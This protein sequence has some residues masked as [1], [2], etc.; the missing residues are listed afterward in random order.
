VATKQL[1]S[2]DDS[3]VVNREEVDPADVVRV[4]IVTGGSR[5]I[6]L[7]IVQAFLLGQTTTDKSSSNH[8]VVVNLDV[9]PRTRK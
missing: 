2:D 6:G 5:G 7:A 3:A 4:V 1:S 9:M 8:I